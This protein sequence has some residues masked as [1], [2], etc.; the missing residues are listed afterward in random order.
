[1]DFKQKVI[2]IL[3]LLTMMS[4]AELVKLKMSAQEQLRKSQSEDQELLY[5][6]ARIL[7][8]KPDQALEMM[9]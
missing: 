1:M 9:R 2:N 6:A 3:P 5:C 4:R 8:E 7:L